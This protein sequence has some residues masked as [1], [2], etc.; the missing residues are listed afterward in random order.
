MGEWFHP[1]DDFCDPPLDTLQQF[2][3]SPLL[4]TPHLDAVLQVKTHQDRVEGQ[5]H[6]PQ[7]AGHGSL[8]AVHNT[9]GFL[10]CEGTLLAGSCPAC[11]PPVP[12][13]P[14]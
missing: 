14:F 12:L 11:Y 9:V 5:D 4:R 8:D 6:L 13:S 3:V 2:Y 1:F 10:G 7:R